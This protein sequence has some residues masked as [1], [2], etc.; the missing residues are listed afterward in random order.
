MNDTHLSNA[1]NADVLA[2]LP[3]I[4]EANSGRKYPT[5]VSRVKLA[6]DFKSNV[7]TAFVYLE[8]GITS[9]GYIM[10]KWDTGEM[11]HFEIR[12]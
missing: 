11:R 10:W 5:N 12:Y 6:L 9:H 1:T 2:H 8:G 3:N 7:V 4:W